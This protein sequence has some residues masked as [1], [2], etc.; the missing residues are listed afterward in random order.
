MSWLRKRTVAIAISAIISIVSIIVMIIRQDDQIS[1]TIPPVVPPAVAEIPPPVSPPTAT[2]PPAPV[3]N[4]TSPPLPEVPLSEGMLTLGSTFEFED[5]L[6]T[7][8]TEIGWS[9]I[10]RSWHD[11]HG[12]EV[13][14]IPITLTNLY[15]A[16]NRLQTNRISPFGPDGLRLDDVGGLVDNDV[17]DWTN[18][19]RSGATLHS[20]MHI[21]YNGSGQYVLEFQSWQ[22]G[23]RSLTEV[24]IDVRR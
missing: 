4:E 10:D 8:G 1:S 7:L 16:T 23:S 18:E 21:L 22:G 19:M 13:F 2:T 12:Q 5:L 20:N 17:S 24:F 6:I 15:N 3:Q 11:L 14:Y 9:T